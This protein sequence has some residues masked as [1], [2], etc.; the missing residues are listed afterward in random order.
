MEDVSALLMSLAQHILNPNKA[1]ELSVIVGP[2]D[3]IDELYSGNTIESVER[4][5]DCQQLVR[6][7]KKVK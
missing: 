6:F 7:V 5:Q 1:V 3:A 2:D 4:C